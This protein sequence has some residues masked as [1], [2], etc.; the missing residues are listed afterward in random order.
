MPSAYR[1][2]SFAS[3]CV[4][5]IIKCLWS[6]TKDFFAIYLELWFPRKPAITSHL[7]SSKF[8]C[9]NNRFKSPNSSQQS[10]NVCVFFVFASFCLEAFFHKP[11][12]LGT[13]ILCMHQTFINLC[14][15]FGPFAFFFLL[16]QNFASASSSV[17]NRICETK[18]IFNLCPLPT[19]PPP[20][21]NE[22]VFFSA[23]HL[24][25]SISPC[26]LVFCHFVCV[27]CQR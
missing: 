6:W 3:F 1:I 13:Y 4:V 9:D 11:D 16:S 7:R 20:N 25:A 8:I 12:F 14:I 23:V 18:H 26:L 15:V 19:R 27:W 21:R 24:T 22:R 5:H 17:G 10:L 2:C